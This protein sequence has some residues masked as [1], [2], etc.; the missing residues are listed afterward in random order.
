MADSCIHKHMRVRHA[1]TGIAAMGVAAPP[2]S[3][4]TCQLRLVAQGGARKENAFPAETFG[5]SES[6]RRKGPE[7]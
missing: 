6:S 2:A 3:G 1:D 4:A 7:N 5:S